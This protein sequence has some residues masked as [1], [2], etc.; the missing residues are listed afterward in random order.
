MQADMA[1]AMACFMTAPS[2]S[3]PA[4]RDLPSPRKGASTP[5][6]QFGRTRLCGRPRFALRARHGAFQ[7]AR[8]A[9]AA[10]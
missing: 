6:V 8:S 1:V 2:Y 4:R 3:D 5:S 10:G 9:V 7:Q